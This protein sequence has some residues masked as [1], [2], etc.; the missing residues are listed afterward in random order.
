MANLKRKSCFPN[1]PVITFVTGN[2]NKL[3]EM[4][5][6]LEGSAHVT[7]KKIDLLEVQGS[8][9]EIVR[10]KCKLAATEVC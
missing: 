10:A 4:Q 7:N 5:T 6:L 9:D 8:L 1:L 2:T 3:H